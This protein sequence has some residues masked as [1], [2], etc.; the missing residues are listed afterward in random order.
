ML[1]DTDELPW[2]LIGCRAPL[3]QPSF[4]AR[5]DSSASTCIPGPDDDPNLHES[6]YSWN[7]NDDQDPDL[8]IIPVK[9]FEF[10]F[11]EPFSRPNS[12][13]QKSPLSICNGTPF[14]LARPEIFQHIRIEAELD[15]VKLGDYVDPELRFSRFSV[16]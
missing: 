11:S 5:F 16:R 8:G 14:T 15:R 12:E 9:F 10:Y 3:T 4:E 7:P 13:K 1:D 2:G 6:L